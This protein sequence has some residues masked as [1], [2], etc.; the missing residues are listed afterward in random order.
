MGGN[1]QSVTPNFDRLAADGM[2]FTNAHCSAPACNPS[3]TAIFSGLS[4]HKTGI[5]NN[6]QVMREVLPDATLLPRYFSDHGYWSAGSGKLLHYVVDARSWDDYFPEKEKENPFP[7]SYDPEPRPISLPRAGAWQYVDTDWGPL[8]VSDEEFG[9]DW[10]VS[11]WIGKQLSKKH[12]KPFFL[13]C[14]IY[15]P[16]EPWFVPKQYFDKFP[17]E[18]IKLPP[19]YKESD[20]DDVPDEGRNLARN[21]YL[22]HIQKQGQWK[23]AIQSYLASI[24]YADAMLGRVLDALEKGPNKN[25]TIVVLWSDHGWHLGEKEHWQKYTGW[26]LS[27]RVPLM[28]KVPPG[29]SPALPEGATA[30]SRCDQPVSLLGLFPTLNELCG[31]PPKGGLDGSSIVPLLRNPAAPGSPVALTFL[32]DGKSV[33]VSGKDWRYIRYSKGGEELYHVDRDP[34]EWK[35]LVNDPSHAGVL[36]QL[37][38]EIPG[39]LAEVKPVSVKDLP[40][41]EWRPCSEIGMLPAS[42]PDGAPMRLVL[43]NGREETIRFHRATNQGKLEAGTPLAAATQM[44]IKAEPGSVWVITR[45]PDNLMLGYFKVQ[46]RAAKAV[47]P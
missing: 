13:A 28:V 27:T 20:L 36:A 29:V 25:N 16:H 34:Y 21:R 9:G 33:S 17:L 3:R 2:L 8:D 32:H 41:L 6:A 10:L 11:G 43:V 31:L 46:D 24:H 19:G 35:N 38:A 15:R 23:K 22:P 5:Y 45:G 14:G 47:V 4:P 44:E 30:G 37:R 42:E 12:Q 1:P 39:Q 18:S 7:R 40:A 26:R